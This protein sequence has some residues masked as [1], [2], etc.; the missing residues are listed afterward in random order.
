MTPMAHEITKLLATACLGVVGL[1]A[2]AASCIIPDKGIVVI[3]PDCGFKWCGRATDAFGVLDNAWAEILDD[4]ENP[5]KGCLCMTE[6]EDTTLTTGLAQDCDTATTEMACDNLG[7]TCEWIENVEGFGVD[8]CLPSSIA[9]QGLWL[10][11]VTETINECEDEATSQGFTELNPNCAA[12]SIQSTCQSV[13]GCA[14]TGSACVVD[15]LTCTM[16]A[17]SATLLDT[18]DKCTADFCESGNT[19]GSAPLLGGDPW[20]DLSQEIFCASSTS[21]VVTQN[22]VE[23]VVTNPDPMLD[24]DTRLEF[25]TVGNFSGMKITGIDRGQSTGDLAWRLK[26]QNNDLIF[27]VGGL[28]ITNE[29]DLLAV[30]EYLMTVSAADVKLR[31]SSNTVTISYAVA[32]SFGP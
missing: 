15:G 1:G 30:V 10:D 7:F 12:Q 18:E 23:A 5:V 14:W 16:A 31:R 8:I 22:L 32:V 26:L 24:D 11:L 19:G 25:A 27:E 4:D 28:P 3:D 20:G 9:F 21:C 2:V 29:Q 13:T 17:A 6:S